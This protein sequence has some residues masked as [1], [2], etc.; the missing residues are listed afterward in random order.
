MRSRT[1]FYAS[2]MRLLNIELE[3]NI[4]IFDQFMEPITG[5]IHILIK[6]INYFSEKFKEIYTI[7]QNGTVNSVNEEQ[8]RMAVIGFVRD[9][10]GIALACTKKS[11]YQLFLNWW[12]V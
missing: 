8:L 4:A 6:S 1:N 12:S 9:L 7:F 11:N 10:R 5:L 3:E 2:L